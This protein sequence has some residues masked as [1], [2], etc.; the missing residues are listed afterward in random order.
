MDVLEFRH[1]APQ[2]PPTYGEASTRAKV[3]FPVYE[4]AE[5][6]ELPKYSPAVSRLTLVLRKVEF[7]SPYAPSPVRTWRNCVMELNSTQLNFYTIE[8]LPMIS[9]VKKRKTKKHY[10]FTPLEHD[11]ICA[12]ISQ[13]TQQYLT[14]SKLIRSYSLQHARFGLPVDYKK[15]STCLRL[16]CESEQ[17]LVH[18]ISI[19]EM[20][21]WANDVSLGINVAL[22][23]DSREIPADR[24]VPRRRRSRRSNR[25][26]AFSDTELIRRELAEP[27]YA[28]RASFT[29]GESSSLRGKISRIF[30]KKREQVSLESI[31]G[32]LYTCREVDENPQVDDSTFVDERDEDDENENEEQEVELEHD[33]DIHSIQDL[34]SDD[35]A[36]SL[37]ELFGTFSFS[38][39]DEKWAPEPKKYSRRKFLKD[40]IRCI[41]LL[42]TNDS[43]LG[44]RCVC[45][46][47]PPNFATRNMYVKGGKNKHL[48]EFVVG[49]QGFVR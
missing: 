35:D 23:L 27:R 46:A 29:G 39:D 36:D 49:V 7:L 31:R 8:H 38:S 18:F 13:N 12:A 30:G 24:I 15:R 34:H 47:P 9:H 2:L 42:Q 4:R 45:A 33:A 26:R 19:D 25:N 17:F 37:S 6:H 22:D 1:P 21:Q 11:L 14:T 40:S 16:R 44:K 48:Q 41:R 28:R 3:T 20:I 10:E 32:E 5:T 43:W